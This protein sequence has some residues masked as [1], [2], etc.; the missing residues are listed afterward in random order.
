M[1]YIHRNFVILLS[2]SLGCAIDTCVPV[3]YRWICGLVDMWVDKLVGQ[4]GDWYML[5][6]L[7][8]ISHSYAF[9]LYKVVRIHTKDLK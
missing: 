1:F 2:L 5:A 3:G 9:I 7:L 6:W 4:Y 8:Q